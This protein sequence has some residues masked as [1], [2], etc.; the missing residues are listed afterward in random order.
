MNLDYL[1]LPLTVVVQRASDT[2]TDVPWPESTFIATTPNYP[3]LSGLAFN[4]AEATDDLCI[5]VMQSLPMPDSVADALRDAG[6]GTDVVQAW[7]RVSRLSENPHYRHD[8]QTAVEALGEYASAGI[9]PMAACEFFPLAPHWAAQVQEAGCTPRDVRAYEQMRSVG[10]D[11][12][13]AFDAMEWLIAGVPA[14]RGELY[15]GHCSV[16]QASAWD[17]Y[18]QTHGLSDDDLRDSVQIGISPEEVAAGFPVH[19]A[20]M[21]AECV[22][23]WQNAVAW[24]ALAA[25]QGISDDNLLGL[26][27][28]LH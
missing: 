9:P 2:E 27:R 11:F 13:P 4:P 19:R 26:F 21:Y 16:E 3:G 10:R 14:E 25:Q 24:E 8:P 5:A 22:A 18:A 7:D 20:A 12:D 17:E 23:P 28:H 6:Y 1:P 15:V